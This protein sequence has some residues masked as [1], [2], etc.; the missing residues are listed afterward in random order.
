MGKCKHCSIPNIEEEIEKKYNISIYEI[1][2][3]AHGCGTSVWRKLVEKIPFKKWA[4]RELTK[5]TANYTL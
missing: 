5:N 2:F 1:K 3:I 4:K